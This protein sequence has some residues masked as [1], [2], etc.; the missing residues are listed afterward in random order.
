MSVLDQ[1]R[2]AFV[3]LAT[4]VHVQA[5]GALGPDVGRLAA[6]ARDMLAAGC[7]GVVPFGTTGEGPCF[8][9]AQRA[10]TLDGLIAAGV[11][12]DRIVVGIG[13]TAL[14]DC[15][16]L[17]RHATGQG[18][19]VLVPPPFFLRTADEAGIVDTF[20]R[21]A[22]QV[23]DPRLRVLVYNIPQVSGFAIASS[24]L[25]ALA[26]AHPDTV[27]GVKDSCPDWPPLE[28]VLRERGRLKVAVGAEA[29]IQQAMALGGIGTICGMA[30]LAP[31]TAARTVA[32]D[33][34][35]AA[36]LARLAGMFADRPFLAT[37]KA[38]L[39]ELRGD[40]G[41]RLPMPPIAPLSD[42]RVAEVVALARALEG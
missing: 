42:A 14:A 13:A 20:G 25:R 23:A 5:D 32:G 6:L 18:C 19:P 29:F 7:N 26:E 35:A 30:N 22:A 3:A 21:L 17:A 39:A 28:P 11:P 36:G 8:S 31:R 10:A 38:A 1:S 27:V 4:P 24:A 40:E 37:L 15:V 16:A 2:W 12:G 9:V 41:W 33:A 34:E